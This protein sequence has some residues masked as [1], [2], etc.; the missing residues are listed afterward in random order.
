MKTNS[1]N[2][3]KNGLISILKSAADM[4]R[5]GLDYKSLLVFLFYKALSDKWL[6]RVENLV[7]NEK[8]TR[9]SAY[10]TTN[11]EYY[12]LFDEDESQLYTWH[13][14]VKVRSS[15]KEMA[16]ALVK[17]SKLNEELRDLERLVE[18]LGL[19]GYIKEERER[20]PFSFVEQCLSNL[21]EG[22]FTSWKIFFYATSFSPP[23]L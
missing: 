23:H 22:I 16:N 10:I 5:G 1:Q 12:V 4:I 15:I 2:S 20:F 13:E 17:I 19:V 8:M 18:M 11:K 3:G 6:K 14:I 7:E 9:T 21:D